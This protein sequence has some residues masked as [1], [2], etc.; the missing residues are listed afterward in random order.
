MRLVVHE[1]TTPEHWRRFEQLV[2]EYVD[3]LP[4]SLEF[5]DL[6]AELAD[7]SRT[8]GPPGGSALVAEIDGEP[9]GAVG[10]RHL[11]EGVAELKRMYV[12]P[13]SRG[14]GAGRALA[15]RALETARRLGYGAV[16]LDT[17]AEMTTAIAIYCA[18]GFVP[19]PAY[20]HNPLATARFFEARLWVPTPA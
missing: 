12:R 2:R 8:Y 13:A 3:S 18:L 14:K 11:E 17:A 6:D 16:R 20:R 4:F 1:G 15:T 5:Q 7:L 10:L 9:V 19:I